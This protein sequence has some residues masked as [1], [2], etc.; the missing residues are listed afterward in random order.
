METI[1][2]LV[3]YNRK[4]TS[5]KMCKY[6]GCD[7]K[8]LIVPRTITLAE[9]LDRVHQIGNTNSR[10]DK[11]CLKFSVLV[12][13]NEWKH[14]KIEDDDDVKFVMKYNC[15]YAY[16]DSN[17]SNEV[18]RNN[19]NVADVGG[20]VGTDFMDMI[21]FSEVEEMHGGDNGTK[22]NEVSVYSA[23]SIFG[24]L[25][26]SAQLP[27]IRLG[28]ESEPTR[29]HYLSQMGEQN[30]YNVAGVN[31]VEAYLDTGYSRS[32]WNPKITVGQIFTSK[33]ALLTEL[34][35]TALRRHF[36]FKVQF[37]CTKRLLVVC[38]QRPCPWQVGASRIREYNFMIVRC[39]TV[40]ECDLRFVNDN[41]RQATAAL[42]ATSF[43]KKLKD[44]WTIYTPSDIMRDVKHNFGLTI[45][46]SKAWKANELALLSIR[47]LAEEAYYIL[48]SYCYELERMNPDTKT[49]IQTDE[50]NH[51]V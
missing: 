25:N 9:L 22:R 20:D 4:L 33:G 38:C 19:T 2:I 15:E 41:H 24:H 50:N 6:E 3:C 44:S 29:E 51:F 34:Q 49:H 11:V 12:S 26:T 46:Y 17:E 39:T 10:E 48:P 45:H 43:K 42:V 8:G 35:L 31:D 16:H 37:S 14:I 21:D 18:T 13:S 23:P 5:K 28:G 1:V 36:E 40:Q 7:S 32:D 27:I 30:R 47:G